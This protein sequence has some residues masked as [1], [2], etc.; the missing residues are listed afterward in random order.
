MFDGSTVMKV[1]QYTSRLRNGAGVA[2]T[3][4][5][6]GLRGLG[7]DSVLHFGEGSTNDDS[8]MVQAFRKDGFKN[9]LI[10]RIVTGLQTRAATERG[11]VRNPN[12]WVKAKPLEGSPDII[13]IHSLFRWVD[14]VSFFNHVPND[15]P[16]VWSLHDF[17]PVSGGCIYPGDCTGFTEE[18]ASCPQLRASFSW[19]ARR[20][21]KIKQ[22]LYARRKIHFVCNSVWTLEQVNKASLACAAGSVSLIH[23]GLNLDSYSPIDKFVAK[24][25]LGLPLQKTVIGFAATDLQEER[26]GIGKLVGSLE[27]IATDNLTLLSFGGGNASLRASHVHLGPIYNTELQ[28]LFYSAIDIFVTPSLVETFGNTAMEAMA[29]GT[30]VVGYSTSGLKDVVASGVTGLLQEPVG[31]ET[32]IYQALDFLVSNPEVRAQMGVAARRRVEEMFDVRLMA[33]RY[34]ELYTGLL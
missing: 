26:K 14:L 34:N 29:C 27:K 8:F 11:S 16:I 13:H 28:R 20:N 1:W 30:P 24:A 10:N 25:A 15:V 21:H 18:C 31:C 5:H 12:W 2:A 17:E 19:I 9:D 7:V 3:R 23:L 4:L 32:S 33:S 6:D 22:A